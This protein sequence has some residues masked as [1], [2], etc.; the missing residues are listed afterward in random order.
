MKL[1]RRIEKVTEQ[2]NSGQP[3]GYFCINNGYFCIKS[4]YVCIKSGYVCITRIR[5]ISVQF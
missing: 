3:S 4:G 1:L 2:D 5:I